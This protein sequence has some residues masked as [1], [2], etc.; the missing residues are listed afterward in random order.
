[1]AIR[2]PS[3]FHEKSGTGSEGCVQQVGE[4]PANI[5]RNDMPWEPVEWRLR[6]Q[7][8][9][10]K[11]WD[12][13]LTAV[14]G[15]AVI[16][17]PFIARADVPWSD[18]WRG[19]RRSM[20]T[21][22]CHRASQSASEATVWHI[23]S[24]GEFHER[25]RTSNQSNPRQSLLNQSQYAEPAFRNLQN[26]IF[27]K[28]VVCIMAGHFRCIHLFQT[29]GDSTPSLIIN[30]FRDENLVCLRMFTKRKNTGAIFS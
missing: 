17:L 6:S 2:V 14:P 25:T 21:N 12:R 20:E 15:R 10:R 24:R 3:E 26:L 19:S 23:R 8:N 1:M 5:A 16:F 4:L 11:V 13:A 22:R 29:V 7:M 28:I 18:V 9:C 30:D 27:L